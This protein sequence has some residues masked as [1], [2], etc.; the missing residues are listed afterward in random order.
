M[1]RKRSKMRDREGEQGVGEMFE[2][3]LLFWFC[4]LFVTVVADG[5]F[6]ERIF[7][8]L[9]DERMREVRNDGFG[10]GDGTVLQ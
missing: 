10:F 7:F 8:F 5:C 9:G 3:D 2:V 6:Q 4:C 1:K